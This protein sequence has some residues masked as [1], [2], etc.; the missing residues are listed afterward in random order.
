MP[1]DSILHVLEALDGV[2]ALPPVL[3]DVGQGLLDVFDIVQRVVQL[4]Q[5]GTHAVQLGLDRS[6][7]DTPRGEGRVVSGAGTATDKSSS[8]SSRSQE[9]KFNSG[10]QPILR[11]KRIKFSKDLTESQNSFSFF[12]ALPENTSQTPQPGPQPE[13][14]GYLDGTASACGTAPGGRHMGS[15]RASLWS[16]GCPRPPQLPQA[17]PKTVRTRSA[18]LKYRASC[19][20]AGTRLSS[21]MAAHCGELL[22]LGSRLTPPARQD[23]RSKWPKGRGR[24]EGAASGGEGK[25]RWHNQ[26]QEHIRPRNRNSH[27][28]MVNG[29]ANKPHKVSRP[30]G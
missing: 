21:R 25:A 11:K 8:E 27:V 24:E 19:P 2:D 18:A 17:S 4:A 30:R 22:R 15:P 16:Q 7:G 6:L 23:A 9:T 1:H 10:E 28:E 5:A 14:S 13:G 29:D 12:S 3:A 26:S 20:S